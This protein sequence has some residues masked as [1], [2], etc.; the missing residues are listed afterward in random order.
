[1]TNTATLTKE[2]K[3][4]I[5]NLAQAQFHIRQANH[6]IQ[7][8]LGETDVGTEYGRELEAIDTELEMDITDLWERTG[9]V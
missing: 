6:F 1:M 8:A 4:A 2:Q 5:G 7:C 9:V 3:A